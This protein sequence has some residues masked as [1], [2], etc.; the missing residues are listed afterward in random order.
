MPGPESDQPD[1]TS[2]PCAHLDAGD[3]LPDAVDRRRSDPVRVHDAPDGS[4]V[5]ADPIRSSTDRPTR[6]RGHAA[7]RRPARGRELRSL[8]AR[9]ATSGSRRST[10]PCRPARLAS[11]QDAL[12]IGRE[13]LRLLVD[14]AGDVLCVALD[15]TPD[16]TRGA[17]RAGTDATPELS[18]ALV[19]WTELT[20]LLHTL[21]DETNAAGRRLAFHPACGH[22]R[23]DPDEIDRLMDEPPTRTGR[24]SASM[25]VIIWSPAAIR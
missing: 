4:A 6:V 3:A 19:C 14:G 17:G 9:P 13:R 7:R 21:A 23:R 5:A 25:S 22:V 15:G 11:R 16:R 12:A 24:A 8:L 1:P 10:P 2:T 20:D 18:D